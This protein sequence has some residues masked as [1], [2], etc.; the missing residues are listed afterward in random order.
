MKNKCRMIFALGKAQL[1]ANLREKDSLF[2]FLAFPVFLLAILTLIFGGI[3]REG[4]INFPITLVNEENADTGAIGPDFAA[5]ITEI[6]VDLTI[7]PEEGKEPLFTLYRPAVDE[8]PAEFLRQEKEALR[9]GRRKAIIVIPAGFNAEI[10]NRIINGEA[11]PVERMIRLYYQHG[12]IGSEIATSIIGEIFTGIDRK[13][14]AQADRLDPQAMIPMETAMVGT[15]AADTPM[16]YIDFLLPG[17][18]L[19]S[20]LTVGLFN[21]PLAI[22]FSRDMKVLRRYWVTPLS[23]AGYLSGFTLSQLM[24]CAI[25]FVLLLLVGRFVFG[26]AVDFIRAESLLFL[27]LA[28]ITFIAFGFF[29]A[30]IAKRP[31]SGMAIAN[32]LNMPM[33]FLGGL[34]FPVDGLPLVLRVL[35]YMNPVTYLAEGLRV[36]MGV[37]PP[38]FPFYLTILI[39]LLWIVFS[40]IWAGKRL[41]WDVGK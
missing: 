20:F 16:R 25:Q 28:F 2:W 33:M 4:E 30:A 6:F 12:D 29:I 41:H 3:G 1:T 7:A 34:F 38:R 13:I 17:I 5:I 15:T 32:M 24:L 8:E 10:L 27:L 37:A 23:T 35:V 18:I 19:M 39:P 40:L 21:V 11:A 9:Y 22:L 31:N 26:A 14:L 36:S